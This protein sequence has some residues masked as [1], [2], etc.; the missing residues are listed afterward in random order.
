MKEQL[1]DVVM[2]IGNAIDK[3]NENSVRI[4]NLTPAGSIA[5][6]TE[7]REVI[8]KDFLKTELGLHSN[9]TFETLANIETTS[10][11]DTVI[12]LIENDN[13]TGARQQLEEF[14]SY[15]DTS[16]GGDLADEIVTNA[17][18]Q[19]EIL[20]LIEYAQERIKSQE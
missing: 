17:T 1:K 11:E 9:N 2:E 3:L 12:T 18:A 8:A 20:S 15:L 6:N 10:P 14:K 13:L 7:E 19:T 5:N 4:D 16:Q